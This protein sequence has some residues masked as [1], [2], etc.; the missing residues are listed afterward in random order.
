MVGELREENSLE[1][2]GYGTDEGDGTVGRGQV[3]RFVGL[4]MI[5]I[6]QNIYLEG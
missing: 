5:Q 3:T 2:F 1:D 4:M 6:I